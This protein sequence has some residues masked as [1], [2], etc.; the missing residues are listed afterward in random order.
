[1]TTRRE[2]QT[3][4]LDRPRDPHLARPPP[5]EPR[6]A[7]PASPAKRTDGAEARVGPP[8]ERRVETAPSD[9]A[10][11]GNCLRQIRSSVLWKSG[12]IR[13]R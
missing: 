3:R 4:K 13:Q 2:H 11:S 12:R 6:P 9:A 8:G 1:M 5:L 7:A 10:V